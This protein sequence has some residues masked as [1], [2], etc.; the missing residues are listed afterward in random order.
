M[1]SLS[2][3]ARYGLQATYDLALNQGSRLRQIREVAEDQAIP[4]QFLEQVLV[5]LKRARL[6]KSYRGSHGG[7]ALARDAT[8]ITGLDVLTCL[9]GPIEIGA[10]NYKDEIL[11]NL[12]EYTKIENVSTYLLTFSSGMI[13]SL[14]LSFIPIYHKN[15]MDVLLFIPVPSHYFLR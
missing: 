4:Q 7:Y 15:V 10:V 1:F 6:V 13:I 2:A 3:K 12:L 5:Q 14:V 11:A 8:K 9:E